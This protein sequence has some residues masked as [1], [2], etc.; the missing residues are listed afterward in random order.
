MIDRITKS[1]LKDFADKYSLTCDASEIFEHFVNYTLLDKFTQESHDFIDANIGVDGTIGIDGF[2]LI[3]N[4]RFISDVDEFI[5]ILDEKSKSNT[6]T[7]VFIQSKIANEF[8]IKDINVF[9]TAAQDF[10]SGS[11]SLQWTEIAKTKIDLLDKLLDKSSKLVKR[12]SCYLYYVTLGNLNSDQNREAIKNVIV[13]GIKAVNIFDDI[14]FE[15]LG[16]REIQERHKNIGNTIEKTFEFTKKLSLPTFDGISEAYI[17]YISAKTLIDLI[18]NENGEIY[19]EIFFE[20]IRDYQGDKGV[21]SDIAQTLMSE[22]SSMFITMNNGITIISE[23][24]S[25][26]REIF[27]IRGFQI[28]NGCQTSHVIFNNKESIKDNIDNIYIPVRIISTKVDVI[29]E[30]IIR[31]TNNQTVVKQQDLIALTSFQKGLEDYFK[32]RDLPVKLYYER[33]DKQ[34]NRRS[35]IKEK[36]IINKTDLIKALT[37][38]FDEKPHL[39]TAFF[40]SIFSKYKDKY[41]KDEHSFSPYYLSSILLYYINEAL[42]KPIIDKKYKKIRFFILMML[43]Y[44]LNIDSNPQFNSKRIDEYVEN[45]INLMDTDEKREKIFNSIV[46]KLESLESSKDIKFT[47]KDISKSPKLTELCKGLYRITR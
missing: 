6:A 1:Y 40:G 10:I 12:P 39:A 18:T 3:I 19:S 22:Y 36:F 38:C 47:N 21:N 7:V 30:R 9:G 32:A 46:R 26:Q 44:E 29:T 11:P 34:Y 35:E 16:A 31:A 27:T 37:S 43:K 15:F 24:I 13:D 8:S 42:R 4:D 45:I 14:K 2:G 20:N 33:K 23:E 25:Q 17:G 41:F 5:D 28:I